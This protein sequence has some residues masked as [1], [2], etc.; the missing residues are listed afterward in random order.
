MSANVL[1]DERTHFQSTGMQQDAA[2]F[3]LFPGGVGKGEEKA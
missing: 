3:V 2:L 1:F